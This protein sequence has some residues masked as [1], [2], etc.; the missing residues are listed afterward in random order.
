MTVTHRLKN[1]PCLKSRDNVVSTVGRAG[2]AFQAV[3]RHFSP[4]ENVHTGSEA[5]PTSFSIH[6]G[7][8]FPRG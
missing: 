8:F 5:Q 2:I 6:I 3:A 4:L 1:T 7:G